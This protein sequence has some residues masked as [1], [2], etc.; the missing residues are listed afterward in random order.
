MSITVLFGNEIDK[1]LPFK[2]I[3]LAWIVY[4]NEQPL[5]TPCYRID[6]RT[7]RCE[8]VR[9]WSKKV[10]ELE[11]SFDV[12]FD[13]IKFKCH[14]DAKKKPTHFAFALYQLTDVIMG[15]C[16]LFGAARHPLTNSTAREELNMENNSYEHFLHAF[17][18][19]QQHGPV[20]PGAYFFQAK[21]IPNTISV[22]DDTFDRTLSELYEKYSQQDLEL[23]KKLGAS[24]TVL[25][26]LAENETGVALLFNTIPRYLYYVDID[27]KIV[28]SNEWI[29]SMVKSSIVWYS[30]PA[31]V[32]KN[33]GLLTTVVVQGFVNYVNTFNYVHDSYREN[34]VDLPSEEFGGHRI[35]YT[36][37]FD[38]EDGS[39]FLMACIKAVQGY[40]GEDLVTNRAKRLLSKYVP[41]T[42]YVKTCDRNFYP[43]KVSSNKA[44]DARSSAVECHALGVLIP[45]YNFC[46][47]LLQS[48]EYSSFTRKIKEIQGND[49]NL[50]F[51]FL[52]STSN[53]LSTTEALPISD[54]TAITYSSI[55]QNVPEFATAIVTHSNLENCNKIGAEHS[56]FDFT[57]FDC[58]FLYDIKDRLPPNFPIRTEFIL[59]SKSS[60]R[61][62]IQIDDLMS[63]ESIQ[64]NRISF[65]FKQPALN[66]FIQELGGINVFR[67]EPPPYVFDR[68]VAADADYEKIKPGIK[69]PYDYLLSTLI[70][71]TEDVNKTVER[72][73][74]SIAEDA[75]HNMTILHYPLR[76]QWVIIYIPTIMLP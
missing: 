74:E 23:Y 18:P 34:G 58:T 56:Y 17:L 5:D 26:D 24:R 69:S 11:T 8:D 46:Q 66:S 19:R 37:S 4:E 28:F 52:E 2:W 7:G 31:D 61:S 44:F 32:A 1:K 47:M 49:E 30:N 73:S 42:M 21:D 40:E 12:N 10:C 9:R 76:E 55:L 51:R 70:V 54:D 3:A 65:M 6:Q 38:C 68:A 59:T 33:D 14:Y 50:C 57:A 27:K 39:W 60:P 25:L 22:I 72:L 20:I 53:T 64:K 62:D 41:G 71:K 63:S 43:C 75:L 16:V 15:S 36:N 29:E 45:V 48:K 67:F 13:G 35:K